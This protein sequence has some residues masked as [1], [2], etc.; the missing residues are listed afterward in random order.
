MTDKIK[1]IPSGEEPCATLL[2]GIYAVG[3]VGV[4]LVCHNHVHRYKQ[5]AKGQ[6]YV[7]NQEECSP[8]KDI[9]IGEIEE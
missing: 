5:C 6:I 4:A 2:D 7:P 8:L 9:H 3:D 1:F